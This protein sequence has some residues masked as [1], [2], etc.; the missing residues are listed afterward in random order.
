MVQD[1]DGE[2]MAA[3]EAVEQEQHIILAEQLLE[4]LILVLEVA[5]EIMAQEHKPQEMAAQ[6]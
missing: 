6:E 1:T 5:E 3:Q 4:Q 2:V